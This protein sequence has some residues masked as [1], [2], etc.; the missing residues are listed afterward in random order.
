MKKIWP[1]SLSLC[2]CVISCIVSLPTVL[3]FGIISDQ[4]V[5]ETNAQAYCVLND[6]G[7]S[8]LGLLF[9]TL[10]ILIRDI[11]TLVL[12]IVICFMVFYHFSKFEANRKLSLLNANL[13]RQSRVNNNQIV[14]E[15]TELNRRKKTD[16]YK[17]NKRF[18]LMIIYMSVSSFITHL[19][20]AVPYFILASS[21]S[22]QIRIVYFSLLT[23]GCF[24]LS[25]VKSFLNI[26]AF[27]V[28]NSNFKTELKKIFTFR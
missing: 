2:I 17:R 15:N 11:I 3:N 25:S 23:L 1:Y 10:M 19:A 14:R 7:K 12:E 4:E 9:S 28:F 27:Y 20:V 6:F 18:L 24:C 5:L 26:F 21:S 8:Q 13:D 16:E 22:S